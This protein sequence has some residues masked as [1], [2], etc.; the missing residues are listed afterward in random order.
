MVA[1]AE[2]KILA[3]GGGY[4]ADAETQNYY[5]RNRCYLPTLG[6]W[7]TRDPIGYQGGINLYEYVQSSPVG[8]SNW[9]GHGCLVTFTC[10]LARSW[11]SRQNSS[12]RECRYQCTEVS[13]EDITGPGSTVYCESASFPRA[14]IVMEDD[15]HT[16]SWWGL[17]GTPPRCPSSKSLQKLYYKAAGGPWGACSRS[18]CRKNCGDAY[19][20]SMST[21]ELIP[22]EKLK[23]ACKVA[24]TLWDNTCISACNAICK[25]P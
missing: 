8:T 25:Q 14:P 5:V 24:A 4:N 3:G 17:C 7:L 22:D 18:K 21:C 15:S 12:I 11:I 2:N 1:F 19:G 10:R 20:N 9:S 13:R 16:S 6:R 23:L